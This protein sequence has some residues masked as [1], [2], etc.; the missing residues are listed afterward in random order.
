MVYK[1]RATP[2]PFWAPKK[3]TSGA[4]MMR[5]VPMYVAYSTPIEYDPSSRSKTELF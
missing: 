5:D 4:A 3:S 1:V 2:M